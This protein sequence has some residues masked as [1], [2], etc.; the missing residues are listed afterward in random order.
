MMR[1]WP[2]DARPV[3]PM[4]AARLDRFEALYRR[5]T[6]DFTPPPIVKIAG[7]CGKGSVGAML[8][9]ALRADGAR[10]GLFTSPHL[11][12]PTERIRVDGR[13]IDEAALHRAWESV[14]AEASFFERLLLIALR[15]FHEAGCRV[16]LVEAAIGGASDVTG[17]LPGPLSLLSSVGLDHVAA[18]GPTLADIARD[19]AGIA[20]PG[21]ALVLG[22][23][24][25][26]EAREAAERSARARGVVIEHSDSWAL[27]AAPRGLDGFDVRV[28]LPEGPLTF[29]LPLP[30]A[31]QLQNLRVVLSALAAL[32][33]MGLV[34]DLA[35]IRGVE[36]L[37]WPARIE[38]FAGPP[39]VLIDAAHNPLAYRA[40]ADF[41]RTEP[42]WAGPGRRVLLLG[43]SES[44]KFAA[45]H[46]ILGPLF[47]AVVGVG[48][49]YRAVEPR[50]VDRV[51]GAPAA[52]LDAL[53][54]ELVGGVVVTGSLYLAG[55][56]RALLSEG[57][58]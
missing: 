30:G 40:L 50:G 58:A 55:A 33:R 22:P 19:K 16:A 57:A 47:D 52:A 6:R 25:P 5:C 46:T 28:A 51:F 53:R 8:E 2:A 10:V 32:K 38:R 15:R 42:T 43:A 27:D 7:T 9:A 13:D 35:C 24:L 1:P 39:P 37:R 34:D 17:R 14:D 12:S 36:R 45:A 44:V 26:P 49:F 21:S 56:V 54:A 41:L 31:F 29:R 20:T 18:L 3:G 4:T 11:V 48:G 23:D